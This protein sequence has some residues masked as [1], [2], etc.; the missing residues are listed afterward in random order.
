MTTEHPAVLVVLTPA[1]AGSVEERL[2]ARDFM[3][4][5]TDRATTETVA[6]L[7]ALCSEFHFYPDVADYDY[8]LEF[9]VRD[10]DD[11]ALAVA[12]NQSKTIA[13]RRNL[14]IDGAYFTA[15]G[16][17]RKERSKMR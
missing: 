4:A 6:G 1:D 15:C 2:G 5:T 12:N 9:S 11:I 13:V 7:N 17:L 8:I 16:V 3:K 10:V 14:T